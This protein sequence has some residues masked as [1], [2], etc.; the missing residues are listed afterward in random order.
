MKNNLQNVQIR[1]VQPET[2]DCLQ[3]TTNSFQVNRMW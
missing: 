2:S 3:T 1:W